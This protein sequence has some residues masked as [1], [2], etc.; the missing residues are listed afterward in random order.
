MH[1]LVLAQHICGTVNEHVGEGQR[2][3][4][5]VVECGPASGVVPDALDFCFPIAARESGMADDSSR[6]SVRSPLRN[7]WLSGKG[8]VPRV[9]VGQLPHIPVRWRYPRK[10]GLRQ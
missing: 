10:S 4:A 5:V 1:E 2:V 8:A 9:G 7:P 6:C 3:I